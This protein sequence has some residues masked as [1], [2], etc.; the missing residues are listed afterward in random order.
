MFRVFHME[1]SEHGASCSDCQTNNVPIRTTNVRPDSLRSG[2][3]HF[4]ECRGIP[5]FSIHIA[6][7]ENKNPQVPRGLPGGESDCFPGC[8]AL[9]VASLPFSP[10]RSH[11]TF[12]TW[13]PSPQPFWMAIFLQFCDLEFS[14]FFPQLHFP[15]LS[16]TPSAPTLQFPPLA[17]PRLRQTLHS[18]NLLSPPF[19]A[20]SK[21][22]CAEILLSCVSIS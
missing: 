12:I 13:H 21:T 20:K 6:I 1:Q 2:W 9:P 8:R 4:Q 22:F 19:G 11:V 3:S 5:F 10:S 7:P 14:P 15:N 17:M 18:P 16:L